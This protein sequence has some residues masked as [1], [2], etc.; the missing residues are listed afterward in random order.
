MTGTDYDTPD[1]TNIRD[2]A[3]VSDVVSAH[4]LA[5]ECLENGGDNEVFD[6]GSSKGFS[7]LEIIESSRRGTGHPIPSINVP[8][9][10]GDPDVLIADSTKASTVLGWKPEFDNINEIILSS[11]KWHNSSS[12]KY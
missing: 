3:H 4:Y 9:R 8:R 12:K 10:G 11:W 6:L 2:Y 7:V 5:I 1:G